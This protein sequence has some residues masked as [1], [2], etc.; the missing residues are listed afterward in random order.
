MIKAFPSTTFVLLHSSYPYTREA[1]YLTAVY[2]NVY[3]DFGEVG[4]QAWADIRR[5][6]IRDRCSQSCLGKDSGRLFVRYWN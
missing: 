2:P 4:V 6:D 1:G 5:V 3:L